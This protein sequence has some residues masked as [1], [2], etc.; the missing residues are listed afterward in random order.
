MN[1]LGNAGMDVVPTKYHNVLTC[2]DAS[3]LLQATNV[4]LNN[5]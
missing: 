4:P 1:V 5:Q 3:L 2:F